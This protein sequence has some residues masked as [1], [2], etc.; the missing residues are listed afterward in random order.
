MGLVTFLTGLPIAVYGGTLWAGHGSAHARRWLYLGSTVTSLIYASFTFIFFA[1]E[2]SIMALA[3]QLVLDWPLVWCYVLSPLVII[4]W[5]C[6]ASPSSPVCRPGP[7]RCGW[8]C[9]CGLRMVRAGP[10][11]FLRAVHGL[12]GLTSGSSDFEPLMFGA[13]AAVTF[14]LV[15]QIGEQVDYLRFMPART[16]ANRWRWWGAVLVA[17]PGWILPGMLKMLGGA[18]LAFVALQYGTS[19]LHRG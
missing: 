9:C 11:R 13:A 4:P 6:T 12:S 17:G 15:L 1:P 8:C 3:L 2:A 18:F 14:A 5:C 19:P 7:S 10:A 16:P